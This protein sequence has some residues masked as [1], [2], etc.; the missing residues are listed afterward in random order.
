MNDDD[1]LTTNRV[2]KFGFVYGGASVMRARSD[3]AGA[4]IVIRT[5]RHDWNNQVQIH[6]TPS[7]L[8]RVYGH[9]E[10]KPKRAKEP[11]P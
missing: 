3:R 10:R 7:G 2:T 11:R 5:K 6:V 4:F 1:D 8:V 9:D